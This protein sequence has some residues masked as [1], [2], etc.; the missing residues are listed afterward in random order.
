[1]GDSLSYLDNHL[2]GLSIFLSPIWCS[3]QNRRDFLRVS[4]EQ[5]QKRGEREARVACVGRF[6]KQLALRARLPLASPLPFFP[7]NKQKITPVL[8]AKF[9]VKIF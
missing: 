3:L 1:M 5:R 9:G 7:R 8:Q 6:A 4:G 2:F